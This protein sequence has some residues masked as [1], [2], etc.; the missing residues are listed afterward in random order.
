VSLLDDLP[1]GDRLIHGD[2]HPG[3]VLLRHDGSP[4]AIDWT[5]AARGDPAADVARSYLIIRFGTVGPDA[6]PMVRALARVGRRV[7]WWGYSRARGVEPES[8]R[9]WLPVVAAARL[10]EDIGAERDILIKLARAGHE[11][12]RSAP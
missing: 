5:G 8:M 9:R 4:V 10:A 7:M 1:D 11:I 6:T 3:N 12:R 2:F